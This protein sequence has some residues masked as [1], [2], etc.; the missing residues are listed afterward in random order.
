MTSGEIT[1]LWF[2]VTGAGSALAV[3]G[4]GFAFHRRRRKR[5]GAAA[6][7]GCGRCG[8]DVRGLPTFACPECGAD[9][10]EVGIVA[11]EPPHAAA[12]FFAAVRRTW[13]R[14]LVAAIAT[15]A[16]LAAAAGL[17]VA[18]I[19]SYEVRPGARATL[20]PASKAYRALVET[21]GR[22]RHAAGKSNAA[23]K[24]PYA[25]ERLT[26]KLA[27]PRGVF[28]RNTELDVDLASWAS[29]THHWVNGAAPTTPMVAFDR[30]ELEQFFRD[31]KLGDPDRPAFSAELDALM[32]LIDAC[33]NSPVDRVV[34]ASPPAGFTVSDAADTT[35][36]SYAGSEPVGPPLL[37]IAG[38]IWLMT[39][40]AIVITGMYRLRD[41]L[42]AR[43]P[44]Q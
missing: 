35:I 1:R 24:V 44:V 27:A 21:A 7:R 31:Q 32:T 19:L 10:R 39:A 12:L 34:R 26:L 38:G 9:L 42:P 25:G 37:E 3:A 8:Y 2:I 6:R 13:P 4:A 16:A 36:V 23:G 11:G 41:A 43:A 33:R 17:A 30:A 14:L 18:L 29:T 15:A 20:E 28:D 40:A 22:V 5:P